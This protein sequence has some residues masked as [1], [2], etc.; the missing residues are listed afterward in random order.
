MGSF[1]ACQKAGLVMLNVTL[2]ILRLLRI[3]SIR[4]HMYNM[5]RV[6][7]KNMQPIFSVITI[8]CQYKSYTNYIL[9]KTWEHNNYKTEEFI[10]LRWIRKICQCGIENK[11]AKLAQNMQKGQIVWSKWRPYL[12]YLTVS[13]QQ[14][15][16]F[17]KV[18]GL[19]I[20]LVK[21]SRLWV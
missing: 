10:S 9:L 18:E 17:L 2:I 7:Q 11:W 4:H 13:N 14:M 20:L 1:T 15:I 3:V 21:Y 6:S 19:K 5:Y 16:H 8:F 12:M